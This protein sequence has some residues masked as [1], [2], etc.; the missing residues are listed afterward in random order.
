[1]NSTNKG[2]EFEYDLG[3]AIYLLQAL[4]YTLGNRENIALSTSESYC[5][6]K[7]S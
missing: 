5:M 6:I 1:M 3:T 2:P 4:V 7:L